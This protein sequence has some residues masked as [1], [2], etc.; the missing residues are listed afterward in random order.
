MKNAAHF[1]LGAIALLLAIAMV[2]ALTGCGGGGDH[3]ED[4]TPQPGVNCQA[5]PELCK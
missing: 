2:V 4:A 1:A 3:P 5:R